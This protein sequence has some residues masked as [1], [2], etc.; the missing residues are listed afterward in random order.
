MP[1]NDG[2]L[3]TTLFSGGLLAAILVALFVDF[4]EP[5]AGKQEAPPAA[6]EE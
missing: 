2:A 6:P 5:K 3:I 1:Q 4:R